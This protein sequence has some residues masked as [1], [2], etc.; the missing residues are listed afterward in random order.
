LDIKG[1]ETAGAIEVGLVVSVLPKGQEQYVAYTT[2]SKKA[3]NGVTAVQ[4]AYDSGG[5]F[6]KVAAGEYVYTF[7]TKAPTGFDASATHTIGIYAERDLSGPPT[8]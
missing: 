5:T 2:S 1:V 3:A 7:H 8:I 6:Q 4:A